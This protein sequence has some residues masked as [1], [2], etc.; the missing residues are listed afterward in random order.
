VWQ[1]ECWSAVAA[2]DDD[3]DAKE[4]IDLL[5]WEGMCLVPLKTAGGYIYSIHSFFVF[6]GENGK[7][8]KTI[9]DELLVVNSD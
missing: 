2:D 7:F 5:V 8:E 4:E 9:F 6:V 1:C 3:V